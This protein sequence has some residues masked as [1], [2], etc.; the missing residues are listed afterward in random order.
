M[1]KETITYVDYNGNE[2]TEDFRFNLSKADLYKLNFKHG[3]DFEAFLNKLMEDKDYEGMYSL[4][5]EILT[6][7]YGIKS[8]DGKRFIKSKEISEEF[9]QTAAYSE[10]IAKLMDDENYLIN[11]IN[12]VIPRQAAVVPAPAENK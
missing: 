12:E 2:W 8:E 9:T 5:E 7:A 4:F 11:F 6:S 3:G 10:L 1:Y